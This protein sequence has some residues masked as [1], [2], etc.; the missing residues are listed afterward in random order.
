MNE[1]QALRGI[2]SIH[3]FNPFANDIRDFF[4][5]LRSVWREVCRPYNGQNGIC[6]IES[7]AALGQ[8]CYAAKQYSLRIN[9]VNQNI[10][11]ASFVKLAEHR[12]KLHRRF[13][14]GSF[15][16]AGEPNIKFTVA[17]AIKRLIVDIWIHGFHLRQQEINYLRFAIK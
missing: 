3:D 10:Q 13:N 17:R 15:F 2:I 8:I 11:V 14:V 1:L 7:H 16:D 12:V 5:V 9:E 4:Y 6:Y